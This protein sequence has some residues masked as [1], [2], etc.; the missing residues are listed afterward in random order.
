VKA[1][2]EIRSVRLSS[3]EETLVACVIA[4]N[5]SVGWGIS[6]TLDA[7]AARHMAEQHAGFRLGETDY[8]SLPG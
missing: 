8:L 1:S 5:G 2:L 6:F 7:T 3:G 4:E